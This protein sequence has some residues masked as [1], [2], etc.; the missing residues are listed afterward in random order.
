VV[1]KWSEVG[2]R[3][4]GN[5]QPRAL[6]RRVYEKCAPALLDEITDAIDARLPSSRADRRA[7]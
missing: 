2:V 5:R 1:E 7:A 4:A 6:A 3:Y